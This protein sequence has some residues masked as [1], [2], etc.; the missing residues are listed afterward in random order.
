MVIGAIEG[1]AEGQRDE[2]FVVVKIDG[3]LVSIPESTLRLA[4]GGVVSSQTKAEVLA[5]AG[6]PR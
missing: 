2:M 3:K 5:A 6:V 4:A 1:V